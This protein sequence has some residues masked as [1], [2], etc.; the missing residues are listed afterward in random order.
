MYI[1]VYSS[2][3]EVIFG[4]YIELKIHATYQT[5]RCYDPEE[6]NLKHLL[7]MEEI[8]PF[9]SLLYTVYQLC[10]SRVFRNQKF[11]FYNL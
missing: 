2:L 6:H 4:A 11:Y 10:L 7:L 8:T 9:A 3:S 5:A 1:E